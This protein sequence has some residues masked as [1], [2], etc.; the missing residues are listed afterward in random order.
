MNKRKTKF[1]LMSGHQSAA[2]NQRIVSFE[3]CYENVTKLEHLLRTSA[4]DKNGIPEETVSRSNSRNTH[5]P[6][7]KDQLVVP[8][9]N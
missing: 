9:V 3:N 7:V 2:Q 6:S 5:H 8:S 4:M 1:M